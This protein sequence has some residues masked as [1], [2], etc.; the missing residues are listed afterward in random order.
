[1][2]KI[3]C[4]VCERPEADNLTAGGYDG[5]QIRCPRCERYDI[6]GSAE[7]NLADLRCEGREAALANAKALSRGPTPTIT[8]FCF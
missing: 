7:A 8:N 5:K 3:I 6:A 2:A 4:P 1:M